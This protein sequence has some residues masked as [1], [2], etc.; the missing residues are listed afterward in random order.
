LT[1]FAL[2]EAYG[3]RPYEWSDGVTGDP[4]RQKANTKEEETDLGLLNEGMRYRDLETG[5]FLTRDPIGYAD[6][7]N[8]YC[9][10]HCN[11]ITS[12]DPLGLSVKV[13][14]KRKLFD[15]KTKVTTIVIKGVLVDETRSKSRRLKMKQIRKRMERAIE[16]G[17]E[18]SDG[19]REWKCKVELRVIDSLN[20]AKPEDH[21]Y[22]ITENLGEGKAAAD[23]TGRVDELGGMLILIR[24]LNIPVDPDTHDISAYG[25]HTIIGETLH[26]LGLAHSIEELETLKAKGMSQEE[27]DKRKDYYIDKKLPEDN[28]MRHQPGDSGTKVEGYQVEKIQENYDK[29]RLN[30]VNEEW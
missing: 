30:K 18:G 1:S 25:K 4:D 28:A 22:S 26:S 17:L 20:D 19:D 9:Y 15:R 6:G 12:F 16:S 27:I 10:V 14:T 2:Y 8:V 13:K 29:G 23:A 3:T 11:P 7:P 21:I 24:P 5:T